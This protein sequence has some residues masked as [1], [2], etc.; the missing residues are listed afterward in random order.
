[1][2]IFVP[3]LSPAI[4]RPGVTALCAGQAR[5]LVALPRLGLRVRRHWSQW[6]R[7]GP[8]GSGYGANSFG[9]RRGQR[10]RYFS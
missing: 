3:T 2:P 5:H 4:S 10:S 7:D 8:A 6:V 1:V 9:S